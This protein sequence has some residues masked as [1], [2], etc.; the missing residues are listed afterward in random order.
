MGNPVDSTCIMS[1]TEVTPERR[2]WNNI[3]RQGK[4]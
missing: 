2:E 4:H 3:G 1:K